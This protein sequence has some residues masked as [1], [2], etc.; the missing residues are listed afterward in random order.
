MEEVYTFTKRKNHII[1]RT[2]LNNKPA[3]PV[4]SVEQ[5]DRVTEAEVYA[6][7]AWTD[8]AHI[9]N[10]IYYFQ[11]FHQKVQPQALQLHHAPLKKFLPTSG[12]IQE[13]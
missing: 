7:I 2:G 5:Q 9:H 13:E 6:E 3:V 11:E 8:E 4:L 12:K 1:L 10:D